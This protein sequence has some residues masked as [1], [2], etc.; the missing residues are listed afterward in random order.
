M[1]DIASVWVGKQAL[2]VERRAVPQPSGGVYHAAN[3]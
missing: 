2:L 1:R 3:G